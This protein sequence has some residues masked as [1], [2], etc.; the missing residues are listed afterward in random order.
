MNDRDFHPLPPEA[1]AHMNRQRAFVDELVRRCFPGERLTGERS[2][3][4]LLQRIIDARILGTDR[5]WEL[6]CLGVALGD[7]LTGL[8]D[9]LAW[10]EVTDEFGTDPTLRYRRTSYNVNALTMISKRIESGRQVDLEDLVRQV[11]ATLHGIPNS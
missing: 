9:G 11:A 3:L 4:E 10:C 1:L 6:Q 2:D 7:L 5:T 8:V